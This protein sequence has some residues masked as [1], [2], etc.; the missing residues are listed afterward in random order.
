MYNVYKVGSVYQTGGTS[1]SVDGST[2][3]NEDVKSEL[4]KSWE[5]GVEVRFFNNRLGL[6][7]AWYKSNATRQLLDLP[8]NSLSGYSKMKINAGDIQNQGIE[9][10]LNATPIQNKEFTWD[11]TLNFSKNENK[12]IELADGVN[13]YPLGG[14]DN[15]K[16]VAQAGHQSL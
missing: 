3:F 8:M 5:A 15:L 2:L 9:I 1:A 7:V 13:Q 10:M 4:I 12:I 11:M 16:I 6:D 14:Y